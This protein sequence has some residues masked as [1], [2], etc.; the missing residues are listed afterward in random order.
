MCYQFSIWNLLLCSRDLKKF[1]LWIGD[2]DWFRQEIKLAL[3]DFPSILALP[4]MRIEQ[5]LN[6]YEL[7][8]ELF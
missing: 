2:K 4:Q 1:S 8:I 5:L 3:I 6:R 7:T